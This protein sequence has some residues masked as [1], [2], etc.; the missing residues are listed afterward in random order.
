MESG[1]S[2]VST[3]SFDD[4]ALVRFR[5]VADEVADAINRAI[6]ARISKQPEDQLKGPV[7]RLLQDG[8]AALGHQVNSVTEST[9]SELG[10]RPDIGVMVDGLLTGYVEIKAPGRGARADRFVG[11]ER[12][13][14]QK[15]QALPNL[16]YTDG[17]EWSLYRNGVLQQRV[18]LSGDV[19]V[20]GAT[21]YGG[22]GRARLAGL[23]R[24]FLLWMPL[25]PSSPR[26]LAEMLAPLC[27]LLR[28][29]VLDAVGREG[30]AIH[31]L[32]A[33]WRGILFPDADDPQFADAYAQ[34]VT[35]ALLLAQMEGAITL[36]T[37]TA[38]TTLNR[39]HGLLA[40][41]LRVLDDPE[42]EKEIGLGIGLLRRVIAAVDVEALG[43]RSADPW[44]Y[45][46]EDFLQAYDPKLRKDRGVYY[47]PVAVVRAQVRLVADLLE[48]RFGKPLAYADDGVVLLDPAAGTGT[49][50]LAALSEGAD[51]VRSRFGDG[52]V[53][54]RADV[55]A[56][57]V[58]AFEILV[59]PYAVC[60][61]RLTQMLRQ[62]GA[63][64]DP[65]DVK[66]FLT[67]TLESPDLVHT[68]SGVLL[69]KR[70]TEESERAREVKSST[71]VLVCIG[72]PP[73]DRQEISPDDPATRRKGSW[74]RFGDGQPD[75]P[76]LLEDFLE[77]AR[78]AGA[79]VH[80]K[81]LYNDYIYFWRWAL[82]KVFDSSQGPGIVSFITASS[83]LRGPAFVG[84][85][86]VMRQTFDDMWIID[87]EGD[88]HGPR[89]TEN[90]FNI[91]TPVAIAVGVRY[92]EA[93]AGRP[94]RTRYARL[95][96]TRE[97]KLRSLEGVDG[98]D[99]LEWEDCFDGWMEPLLP[100]KVGN[101]NAWPKLTDLFP[102]Q[103]SGVKVG[104]TWPIAPTQDVLNNRWRRLLAAEPSQRSNLF[105]DSPTGRKVGWAPRKGNLS[106][107]DMA[108][109]SVSP[110]RR[111]YSYR[112]L[113]RQW[114][115]DEDRLI[116]RTS[117]GLVAASGPRQVYIT[118]LLTTVLGQGPAAMACSHV[119][120]LHHF[121]GSYG[122]ADVIPLYR[123]AAGTRPNVTSGLL[124]TLSGILGLDLTPEDLAAYCYALF[125]SPEYANR[126]SEELAIPGP[127]VPITSEK[128]LFLEAV[129][130]GRR[131]LWLHTYGE[132]LVPH[133]ETPG[134]IPKGSVECTL[135]VP[136]SPEDYP[137]RFSYDA[138]SQTLHV[139]KGVFAPVAPVA[140]E[141]SMSGLRV[142]HSWLSYRMRAPSGRS[143][144][145]LDKIRPERWTAHLSEELLELLWVIEGTVAL[146]PDMARL[147]ERIVSGATI[148]A[149]CL[150]SPTA[151]ERE[152]PKVGE[153]ASQ[154][155]F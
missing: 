141:F 37:A 85:R 59:G 42:A 103:Q 143:S 23:L 69:H 57:N 77:P 19:H 144:S 109:D 46:Y 154:L 62:Q 34:T 80:L 106:I 60:H 128:S 45:F 100:K 25:V 96:G 145:P 8:G 97:E 38:V 44:L 47:T 27:R 99:N 22:D 53:A 110:A 83:Y 43:R 151:S 79:G 86:Q 73:Y 146:Y 58:H 2:L 137:E 82:W 88:N 68:S 6:Q 102:W 135:A 90:V 24:D 114:L 91:Q 142:V 13:Q 17:S 32:A 105:K 127:R 107:Y 120:D 93:D 101:Y 104:R 149:G 12:E 139:G 152:A 49:Y 21:A 124:E 116:D 74:V 20:D 50:P 35:Y 66:V 11:R 55:M 5:A 117:P 29:D 18:T 87:L 113:D 51:R 33:E 129:A 98:F 9:V 15:F 40:Q 26:A 125:S 72:N 10:A 64:L 41:A 48:K 130:L 39:G 111:R 123:D 108:P 52:V 147:L 76:S 89:K 153:S 132:R 84:M 133:G 54:G 7:Q 92:G 65:N 70:L 95:E 115:L 4:A 28:Q 61:L 56:A 31:Q 148:S 122:G 67:N 131:L 63:T 1:R 119:P 3:S 81:N 134:R 121:R 155:S 71:R 75:V 112:S 14:W 140:W 78:K 150:P 30:S 138:S 118:S 36:E 136:T 16:I 126:F 94:A